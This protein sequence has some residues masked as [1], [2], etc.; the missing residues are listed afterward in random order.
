[1]ITRERIEISRTDRATIGTG[2]RSQVWADIDNSLSLYFSFVLD[3]GLKL[4]ETP[5]VQP[6]V[7]SFTL[8][9]IPS[10]TDAFQVLQED[11]IGRINNVFTDIVVNPT[12]VTFLA[13]RDFHKQSLSRLCAFTLEFLPQVLELDD[14]GF[15]TCENLAVRTDCEIVYS[16]V[17]TNNLVATRN[18]RV[19]LSRECDM[20]EHLSFSIFNYF[21]SLVSPVKI[22]PIIFWNCDWDISSLTFIKCSEPDFIECESEQMPVEADRARFHNGLLFSRFKI[23]S[24]F[25]N[26]FN[27]KIGRQPLSQF[28]IYKMMQLESVSYL[29]LKSFINCILNSVKKSVRHIKQLFTVLCFQFYCGNELHNKANCGLIYK[30]LDRGNPMEVVPIPLTA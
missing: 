25:G 28:F 29:G 14:F 7:Q 6:S 16:E 9:L 23:F 15:V 10:F 19:N 18:V 2:L 8:E 30:Y 27:S 11:D 13:A 4:V 21:K 1:M 3:E 5:A 26:S 17:N 24:S 22:L 12:H 20:E